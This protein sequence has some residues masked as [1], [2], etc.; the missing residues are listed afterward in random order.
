MCEITNKLPTKAEED[1][2]EVKL[3]VSSIRIDGVM[4]KVYHFSRGESVEYFRQKKV[5]VNGRLCENNSYSLKENDVVTVR[6]YG[7]FVLDQNLG[8]SKKGKI[9]IA[10]KCYGKK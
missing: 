1:V 7:K 6:G 9:N 2:Q 8:L 5:F 4:A 10:V 3:Q